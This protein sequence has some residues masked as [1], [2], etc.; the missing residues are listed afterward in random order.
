M[1]ARKIGV[2]D[3]RYK[4]VKRLFTLC[5]TAMFLIVSLSTA[6]A[7]E[8]FFTYAKSFIGTPYQYGGTTPSG[9]DCSGYTSYVFKSIGVDLPRTAADQF[10]VGTEVAKSDLIPGDIVFFSEG[11]KRPTHNGIYLGDDKFIHSSTS[12]GVII[13]SLND[14]YYWKDRYI[15]ARRVAN[16]TDSK[17]LDVSRDHWAYDS[18]VLVADKGYLGAANDVFRPNDGVSRAQFATIIA[19]VLDIKAEN[20]PAISDVS[21]DHWAYAA[22]IALVDKGYMAIDDKGQFNPKDTMKERDMYIVLQRIQQD[23]NIDTSFI[24]WNSVNKYL[25]E[26]G[27]HDRSN[28][29]ITRAQF[30]VHLVNMFGQVL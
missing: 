4:L 26:K 11:G 1:V 20:S 18:I 21:R 3:L 17:F 10:N 23:E 14:P 2:D 15:G 8:D 5:M 28:K 30:A 12:K 29:D 6:S 9:F 19:K 25:E 24:S 27:I 22:I 13:S 7:K 16:V